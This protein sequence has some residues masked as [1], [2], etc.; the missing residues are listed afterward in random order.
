[1]YTDIALAQQLHRERA[2]EIARS[3]EAARLRKER[4]AARPAPVP[5]VARNR[6]ARG[7]WLVAHLTPFASR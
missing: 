3:N 6:T 4:S 5:T 1:M 2:A 7:S